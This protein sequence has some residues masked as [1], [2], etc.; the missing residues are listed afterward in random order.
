MGWNR[1]H[2]RLKVLKLRMISLLARSFREEASQL[3]TSPSE[4]D[5][6]VS[7]FAYDADHEA[8]TGATGKHIR[9]NLRIEI[10][11]AILNCSPEVKFFS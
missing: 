9:E 10:L 5:S 8:Y 6:D 1:N 11:E 2:L 3:R 7:L 4:Q